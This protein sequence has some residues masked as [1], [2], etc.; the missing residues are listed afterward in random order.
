MNYKDRHLEEKILKYKDIFPAILLTGARQVGKSTLFS[1]LLNKK[2][3][4]HITFDPVL[5]IENARN[6]PE[7]FLDQNPPPVIL[8]EIQYAPELIP[9]IKR[10]IDN[11]KSPG[12]Y[13]LTGSQNL[14]LLKN[15]SE[16]LAGRVVILEL[17]TM[18]LIEKSGVADKNKETWLSHILNEDSHQID[19]NSFISYKQKNPSSTLLS[20]IWRGGFPG[21]L[22]LHD[23]VLPD[24]F[25][26]YVQTCV[27][28]DIRNLAEVHD[29]QIFSRFLALCAALTAQEINFSQLGRD[30]GVT[31]QT[32]SRWLSILRATYQWFEL[33]PYHG[34]TVKRVSGKP[35]GFI[36]D[37]GIAAF[38]QR[39]SSPEALAGHP[40]LGPLFETHVF[41]E[42]HHLLSCI[43]TP[44]N[45]YHW[46]THAGA[47]ID[48]LLELNGTFWPIEIKSKTSITKADAR[49]ISAFKETYPRLKIGAGLIIAPIQKAVTLPDNVLA[50]PYDL[51]KR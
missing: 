35:K 13:F 23:D 49:G 40:L 43:N 18:T 2:N 42:I 31:P 16:S 11:S 28:R 27:E 8:D 4:R 7:F 29:Q 26:S 44:P 36:S 10:R 38:L 17:E 9:A 20:I 50:I 3:V 39:I 22:D 19:L 12:Q 1:H 21:I 48:L 34:N 14:A 25:K 5:D 15:I 46:R 45:Y 32:A 47:E 51:I 41:L 24:Y 6:D 33:P 30:V 37:T